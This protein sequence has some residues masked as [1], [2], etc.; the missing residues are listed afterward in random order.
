MNSEKMIMGEP[1]VQKKSGRGK[2]LLYLGIFLAV[3]A[4]LLIF[5]LSKKSDE[6]TQTQI[7]TNEVN[8]TPIEEVAQ[9]ANQQET[10]ESTKVS[11]REEIKEKDIPV[12]ATPPVITPESSKN[13][14]QVQKGESL[15]KIADG[16][17][18][19]PNKWPEIYN[20][21]KD[22]IKNPDLIFPHQNVI[23]P[24]NKDITAK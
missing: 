2:W 8:P 9:S 15:W 20:A 23:I 16:I 22:Q 19:N 11:T 12:P 14:H 4:I 10:V 5:L 7:A 21:N 6:N 24:K 13:T 17:Y 1:P 3:A 18:G